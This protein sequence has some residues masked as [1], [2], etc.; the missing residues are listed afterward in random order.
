MALD[1]D[2]PTN[3]TSATA[4]SVPDDFHRMPT[5]G[6]ESAAKAKQSKSRNGMRLLLH[7]PSRN[8]VAID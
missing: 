8:L 2:G 5:I 7:R 1:I 4:I 3:T 6:S